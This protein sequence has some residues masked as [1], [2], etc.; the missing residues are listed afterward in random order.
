DLFTS[1]GAAV[2][3]GQAVVGA[4]LDPGAAP[5]PNLRTGDPVSLIVTPKT[6]G[7]PGAPGTPSLL[8]AGSGGAVQAGRGG[9]AE[10]GVWG[11][12]AGGGGDRDAGGAGGVGWHV[13]VG[14]GG[15]GVVIVTVC[16]VRGAPG[17]TTWSLLLAGAWPA[18][19]GVQRVVLEADS[20]GGVLGA[21]YGLGVD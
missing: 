11:G 9:R 21:R 14:V 2:P 10:G 4:S 20:S 1:K 19:L 3:P 18:G 12:G 8:G 17:A 13:A 7:G 6:A 15:G 5:V 16:A